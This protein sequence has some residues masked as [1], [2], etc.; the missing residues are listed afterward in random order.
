MAQRV[1]VELVDDL[2][3]SNIPEGKG[4]TVTFA[5]DGYTYEID[6]TNKNATAL[7]KALAPFTEKASRVGKATN[8]R[9]S[10]T[11]V[12]SDAKAVR[13]W[14]VSN[15]YEVPERGRIPADIR[16]AYKAAQN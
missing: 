3:G 16:E 1:V 8:R 4:E 14:A 9:G 15:G 7:R 12:E 6:L 2:D 11:K 13:A 5:L 10:K